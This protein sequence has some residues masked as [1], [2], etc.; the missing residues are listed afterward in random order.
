VPCCQ[1]YT[2][3]VRWFI[4][5]NNV[6]E[7]GTQLHI[8]LTKVVCLRHFFNEVNIACIATGFLII[9]IVDIKLI[10]PLSHNL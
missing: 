2:H 6:T 10:A 7:Q 3:T 5:L 8:S 9:T 4:S 1:K